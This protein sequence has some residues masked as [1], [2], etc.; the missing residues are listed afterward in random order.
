[1]FY[2]IKDILIEMVYSLIEV[3]L[4]KKIKKYKGLGGGE[5]EEDGEK[6]EEGEG[7]EGED[8]FKENGDVK[9]EDKNEDDFKK[10]R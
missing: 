1:M 2:E 10:V 3:G 4:I 5:Q 8:K 9:D 7:M 6:K